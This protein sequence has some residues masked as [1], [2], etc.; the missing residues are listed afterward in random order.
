MTPGSHQMIMYTTATD[1][2]PPGTL[3]T[4]SCGGFSASNAPIWTYATQTPTDEFALPTDE[5]TGLPLGQE[6]GAGT[7]AYFQMH[8]LN[9][10]DDPLVAHVVLNAEAYD[11]GVPY[12]KTAAFVTYNSQ[13][14]IAPNA[15]GDV[16]S[17]TCNVPAGAKFWSMST[18]AHKQAVK[19]EIADVT[20]VVFSSTDSRTRCAWSTRRSNWSGSRRARRS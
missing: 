14:S 6:I 2:M 10:G 9:S 11:A 5:G 19:T 4:S 8:Y 7:P 16:E 20:S 13:I 18:H 1:S 17:Q 15:V 12:T 3:T